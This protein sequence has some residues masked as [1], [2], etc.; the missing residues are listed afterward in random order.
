M[1][2]YSL[3]A[4]PPDALG[5]WLQRK[6][7]LLGL[8][9]YGPPHLNIRTPFEWSGSEGELQANIEE[10][11][12]G[13]PGFEAQLRGWRRFPHTIFL[14][15]ELGDGLR[16]AH[17]RTLKLPGVQVG[18]RDGDDYIP[19]LTLALGLLSWAEDDTWR[20]VVQLTPPLMHWPVTELAL[21]LERPGTLSE[22]RR[23][24]LAAP[25]TTD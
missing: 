6:Q 3:V 25:S 11:L 16:D 1:P 5:D 9:A 24:P 2:L 7:A 18:P 22:V 8:A 21:T 13:L 12:R 19:H 10:A 17:E 14:E 23:Y 20:E 4:W 15:A